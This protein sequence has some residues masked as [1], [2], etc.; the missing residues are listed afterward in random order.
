[1][2]RDERN[3]RTTRWKGGTL[4]SRMRG[5]IIIDND[6]SSMRRMDV[7]ECCPNEAPPGWMRGMEGERVE[8]AE[9][10]VNVAVRGGW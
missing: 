9:G 3:D 5:L 10:P 8:T 7:Y 4:I 1:M 2:P 6:M